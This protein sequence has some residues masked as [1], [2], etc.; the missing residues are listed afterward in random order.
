MN[1]LKIGY[2]ADGPWSHKAFHL[3]ISDENIEI[4]FIVPRT[5]STDDTLFTFSQKYD[6][7]FFKG[8]KI[9]S[10]DFLE[11]ATS[12]DCDLFVSMSFDQIFRERIINLP[13]LKTINCHAGKLPFYR[14]RNILNWALI[15]DEKEFGITVHYMDEGIDTG[16]I[17]LQRS[18][19]ITDNDDYSTL[20]DV[21]HNECASILYD[22]VKLIQNNK[23]DRIQQSEIHPEGFYCGRRGPGDENI[24]WNMT[25]REL[26]NFIRAIAK[27]GPIATATLGYNKVKI[28]RARLIQD[29]PCYINTPGQLLKKTN[30]GFLVKTKDSFIE[31]LEIESKIKLRVGDK[32][33]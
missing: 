27:P 26:F 3:L 20:L 30:D 5:D 23:A 16:D 11:I 8:V 25:S 24:D 12:Y 29:A 7:P 9:N 15:N 2:F 14:G 4:V 33:E 10:N 31:I 13:K 32:L 22:A 18:F 17:I 21:A 28:N 19:P 1:R 6:I